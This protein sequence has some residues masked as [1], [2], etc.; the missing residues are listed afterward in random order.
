MKAIL[1]SVLFALIAVISS[2]SFA[3]GLYLDLGFGNAE[4][5]VDDL[6]GDDSFLK[7]P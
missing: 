2:Q 7:L 5:E 1:L 6:E 3:E 4:V